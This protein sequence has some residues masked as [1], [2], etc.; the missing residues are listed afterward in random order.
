[1]L[2]DSSFVEKLFGLMGRKVIEEY[3][4]FTSFVSNGEVLIELV[5]L[6]ENSL[7]K[8]NLRKT[9]NNIHHIAF[10]VTDIDNYIGKYEEAGYRFLNKKPVNGFRGHRVAFMNPLSS[11]GILIELVEV[12]K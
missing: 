10:T 8:R 2:Y 4:V 9:G 11:K 7:S 1:M 12:K 3:N 6:A 5:V